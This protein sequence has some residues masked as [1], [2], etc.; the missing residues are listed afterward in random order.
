MLYP[1]IV[2]LRVANPDLQCRRLIHRLFRLSCL[3]LTST[4]P[5]LPAFIIDPVAIS[6]LQSCMVDVIHPVQSYV[7]N[8]PGAAELCSGQE[9]HAKY[10]ALDA[11]L[12]SRVLEAGYN[13]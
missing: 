7:A 2:E 12:G 3:C 10:S 8:V 1:D 9:S 6:S 4:S 11:T 5:S 13:P